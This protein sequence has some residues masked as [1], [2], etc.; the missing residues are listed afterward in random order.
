MYG[1]DC[2][3]GEKMTN[4]GKN[5]TK[6]RSEKHVSRKNR[7]VPALVIDSPDIFAYASLQ[8]IIQF[9]LEC[10]GTGVGHTTD[11]GNGSDKVECIRLFNECIAIL[12]KMLVKQNNQFLEKECLRLLLSLTEEAEKIQSILVQL[13]DIR[14]NERVVIS[15][16]THYQ[17]LS[18]CLLEEIKRVLHQ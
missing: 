16:F 18:V 2:L 4:P 7:V 12:Q 17:W 14:N 3:R 11:I 10:L 13:G 15:H 5:Q 8:N 1:I 9:A 6:S